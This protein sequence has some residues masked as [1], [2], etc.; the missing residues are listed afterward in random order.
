MSKILLAILLTTLTTVELGQT[1]RS[2]QVP[3]SDKQAPGGE[4]ETVV[5]LTFDGIMVF[6][7]VENH[8][9]VGVLDQSAATGH[10][11]VVFLGTDQIQPGKL[12]QFLRKGNIWRL[13]II[14]PSGQKKADISERRNKDCNRLQDTVSQED[15]KHA[16]DFCWIMDLEN[17]FHNQELEL[18]PGMLKPI[19]WLNN[20]ELYT[21]SKYDQLERKKNSDPSCS[22]YGF[23]AQTIALQIKLQKD[24][25]LVLRVDGTQENVFELP[26]DG[27]NVSIFNRPEKKKSKEKHNAQTTSACNFQPSHFRYY[28]RLFRNLPEASQYDIQPKQ[29]GLLPF[30]RFHPSNKSHSKFDDARKDTFDNQSCGGVLLGRGTSSLH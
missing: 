10:E 11:F 12:K 7:R 5:Q 20:G 14:T 23:V 17:D 24:E 30:N 27:V 13:E 3:G 25:K 29:G 6:R 15:S 8:Y 21:Q 9:E 2:H 4:G 1:K 26:R 18:I 16:Y 19:I 28:Y 22:N